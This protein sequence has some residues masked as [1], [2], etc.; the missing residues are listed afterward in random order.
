MQLYIVTWAKSLTRCTHLWYMR[1]SLA[2]ERAKVISP[3]ELKKQFNSLVA[4]H[5]ELCFAVT[6][7]AG[8]KSLDYC[9]GKPLLANSN[10]AYGNIIGCSDYT[11][12]KGCTVRGIALPTVGLVNSSRVDKTLNYRYLERVANPDSMYVSPTFVHHRVTNPDGDEYSMLKQAVSGNYINHA[13]KVFSPVVAAID[14]ETCQDTTL[15]TDEGKL[16]RFG[17]VIDVFG[18]AIAGWFEG[19]DKTADN[20][21]IITFTVDF[22]REWQWELC[23]DVCSSPIPK[24]FSNGMYDKQYLVRWGI[25]PVNALWDTEYWLRAASPDLTGDYS[26]QAQANMYLQDSRYWKD[27]I[28]TENR[29][30]YHWYNA[31]DC[32]TTASVCIAQIIGMSSKNL[33]NYIIGYSRTPYALYSSVR[34]MELDVPTIERLEREY[35]EKAAEL[36][37]KFKTAIGCGVNQSAKILPMVKAMANINSVA[38]TPDVPSVDATDAKIITNIRIL[39]PISDMVFGWMQDCR[40]TEKWLST[41]IKMD[42]WGRHMNGLSEREDDGRR[43]FLWNIQPFGTKSGRL[44]SN[45]SAFWVGMSAHTLPSEMRKMMKAPE[46]HVFITSDAPQTESRV[47]AYESRCQALVDAVE[48]IHDFHAWNASAFFGI[49]YDQIYDDELQKTLNK[50]LR[51]LAKRTNHGANYNMG[52][53][54]MA[55][56]MGTANVRYA[57]KALNLP[58]EWSII[59]VCAYLL[60]V[61]ANTYPEVKGDWP[62]ELVA[63]VLATGRVT[64][65]ISGYSPVVTGN[66]LDF[67]PDLNTLISLVPQST[68]AYISIKSAVRLFNKWLDDHTFPLN[69]VLQIHDEIISIVKCG[70][71]VANVDDII[72][73][74]CAN[75]NKVKF[76]SDP[77]GYK[78]LVIPVGEVVVGRTWDK[79]KED[80]KRREDS[81]TL[82]EDYA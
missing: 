34:G 41:Y 67:K 51:N 5:K 48:S 13:G 14:L 26:L 79:L 10:V 8:R 59:Q 27:A 25:P 65:Q 30:E 72:N 7:D 81:K 78:T 20:I 64:C 15:E 69:P 63:E 75:S 32:H 74:N 62:L 35:T 45:S 52:A 2:K 9:V 60:E 33:R 17:A 70:T 3:V 40:R 1:K 57:Q 49:P 58:E 55:T 6:C 66:P 28:K 23:R 73:T 24:V 29:A 44:S 18:V 46:G 54:V 31:R 4:K 50:P 43:W 56:T 68:S 80:P 19:E 11:Y 47:T 12:F 71:P 38:G 16:I 21:T 39:D 61:F 53:Y 22:V 77:T 82:I 42:T 76:E 36:N 37:A